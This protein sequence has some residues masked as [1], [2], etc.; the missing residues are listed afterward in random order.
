MI[1]EIIEKHKLKVNSYYES[2]EQAYKNPNKEIA[3]E[4]TLFLQRKWEKQIPKGW[5]GFMGLGHPTP[6]SWFYAI[7]DY[8]TYLLSKNPNF[9]ILQVKVKFGAL[10]IYLD[11]IS[12]E[13]EKELGEL[14][15]TMSDKNLVY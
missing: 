6:L 14:C 12:Q 11:Q 2:K 4:L 3:E 10:I 9:K 1:K 13:T 15:Q 5:Y 7:D 8:F